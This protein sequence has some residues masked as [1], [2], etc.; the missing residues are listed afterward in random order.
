MSAQAMW[1]RLVAPAMLLFRRHRLVARRSQRDGVRG[2]VAT[3]DDPPVSGGQTGWVE[4]TPDGQIGF[5]V[6]IIILGNR[7]IP[8][9]APLKTSNGAAGAVDDRPLAD[10]GTP[11]CH[12]GR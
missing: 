9:H 12:V 6:A 10:R 8:R 7:Y 5:L 4:G 2:A 3:V 1:K 11:D